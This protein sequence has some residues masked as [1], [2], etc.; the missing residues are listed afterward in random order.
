MT[1]SLLVPLPRP[2]VEVQSLVGRSVALE[3]VSPPRHAAEL[4]QS[5]GAHEELWAGTPAG[6]FVDEATFTTW[7]G[8]RAQ[9]PGGAL[10]AIM[11]QRGERPTAAGLYFLLQIVP[12]HGTLELGLVYGQALSKQVPGTEAF[13]L[14]AEH[15]FATLQYRRMEWRCDVDHAA[16]RRAA[17]RFGFIQEGVL[18]ENMW[19]KGK[20]W[21]TAVYSMIDIEWP[22]HRERL[23]AWLSPENFT[24]D[25]LQK[26]AL[27]SL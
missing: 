14:I 13:F 1:R 10:Y 8:D 9:R 7:L 12:Q 16:S 25:G 24:A 18:R 26:K 11:D 15:L 4:W 17:K 2:E 6:P 5:I 19:V 23:R 3:R 20:N 22:A 27:S 21:D